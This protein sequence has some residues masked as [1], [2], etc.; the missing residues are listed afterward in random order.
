MLH[1]ERSRVRLPAG[2]CAPPLNGIHVRTTSHRIAALGVLAI[3]VGG[4]TACGGGSSE[5]VARVAGV[6]SI[7][8]ATL[9]H[10][11]PVEA[12]VLYNEKPTKPVPRGVIPDPPDYTACIAYLITNPQ[13]VVQSGSKP[14]PGQLKVKCWQRYQELKVLTLNTLIGWDWTIGAGLALGIKVSDA[15]ARQRLKEANK[16]LFPKNAEFTDYLRLTQQTFADMLF[17]SR[18]QLVEAK[19]V[20][21]LTTMEKLLPKGL[22]AQ[23]RQR[24]LAQVQKALPPNKQWAQKTTC[25]TG[26]VTSA[27]KQYRGRLSPGLP[28]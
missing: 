18:V 1:M 28:N 20:Q 9:D 11:I 4:L 24:A 19:L 3:A 25:R 6:D 17:R 26:Y 13:K 5:T 21:K 15:E 22:T 16:N 14:T 8:K 2:P 27:C 23:Q 7:S 12:I 10:W